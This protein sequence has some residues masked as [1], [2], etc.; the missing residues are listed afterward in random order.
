MIAFANI[1]DA[2][3]RALA[4]GQMTIIQFLIFVRKRRRLGAIFS[5]RAH[6]R[7]RNPIF[8]E[9]R[10]AP[11]RD[12]FER[13]ALRKR[14][15]LEA[16]SKLRQAI[17]AIIIGG[18]TQRKRVKQSVFVHAVAIVNDEVGFDVIFARFADVL[19]GQICT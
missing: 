15:G 1:G 14:S 2:N 6:L 9:G 11:R 7:Q 13:F 19:F 4:Y 16:Q 3:D 17:V 10:V 5:L 8:E 18:R 12:D